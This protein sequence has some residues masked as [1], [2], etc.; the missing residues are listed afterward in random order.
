MTN[1]VWSSINDYPRMGTVFNYAEVATTKTMYFL[2]NISL[3]VKLNILVL[4]AMGILLLGV[5]ILL[6]RN[7]HNLTEEVGGERIIEETNIIERRL[8]EIQDELR[9]NANFLVTSVSFFQAV[10]S[11]DVEETSEIINLANIS[12]GLD[13]ITVVDGD[14]KRL[15]DT[16]IDDNTNEEDRLLAIALTGTEA[17]TLL[18]EENGGRIEISIAVAA[19]VESNT[20]NI[21]GAIQLSR[22]INNTFLEE[23]IFERERVHLG[24]IYD[25]QILARTRISTNDQKNQTSNRILTNGVAFD[26]NT[27]QLVQTNQQTVTIETLIEGVNGIPHMVAYTPV[28]ESV[29]SV[30]IMILVDLEEISS[31]QN[32]TLQITIAIFV[33]L[34]MVA[35]AIIYVTIFYTTTR[36][37]NR[38]RAIAQAMTEGQYDERAPVDK[39]DE[40]GQLAAA[41][42]NM[43]NA[44]Q[45]REKSLQ[46]A[47]E[48]AEQA[49]KA[50]SMFLASV[51]HELRT[52][53]NAIINLTKFLSWGM[54]GS[55]NEEQVEILGKTESSGKHLLN[56]INDVLDISKIEAGSFELFVEVDIDIANIVETAVTMGS[57][58]LKDASA[59]ITSEVEP[60]LPLLTGDRQRILQVVFNL[61]S[62]ACKFTDHGAIMVRAYRHDTELHITVCDS[63]PGIDPNEHEWIFDVFRQ[64]KIGLRK[65]NGTGLG[66]PISRRLAEAHG[67]RLWLESV[68]GQGATFYFALPIQSTLEPTI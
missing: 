39:K 52:P 11:R 37:L 8:A 13:D 60:S 54:Y 20:G 46:V 66:L 43:A 34:T 44:I 18:I 14:G 16:Q 67:G 10:G 9:V 51:S 32:T 58:L 17:T 24:L 42:N 64:S 29:S 1:R 45:Q 50:K 41:F 23:L 33:A 65:G 30:I 19:P 21:L 5:V 7:T 48:Q 36:P 63:G 3:G 61:V 26:S 27:I 55:V 25:N 2:R 22:Q 6:N 28:S 57:G 56:L 12:L 59:R 68:A 47:R 35:I 40:V 53:L 62:N 31:F 4:S 49:D 38:L 15:V